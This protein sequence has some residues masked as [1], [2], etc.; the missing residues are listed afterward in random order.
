MIKTF[1]AGNYCTFDRITKYIMQ[2]DGKK[3]AQISTKKCL[4][5]FA[6]S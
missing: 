3:V 1:I 2:L 6:T 5:R 4:L